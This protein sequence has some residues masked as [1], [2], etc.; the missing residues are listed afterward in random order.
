MQVL[1]IP[2]GSNDPVITPTNQMTQTIRPFIYESLK[3]GRDRAVRFP[4]TG[5]YRRLV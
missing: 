2:P 5:F 4:F 3:A 1:F